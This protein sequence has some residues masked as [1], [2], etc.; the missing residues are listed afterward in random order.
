M[1]HQLDRIRDLDSETSR[2]QRLQFAQL[3]DEEYLADLWQR[4]DGDLA[5]LTTK[6]V[7]QAAEADN[8]VAR[9]IMAHA[10]EALGWAIAQA[11]T[12]L[13]GTSRCSTHQTGVAT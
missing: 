13:A 4:C 12:L 8:R 2:R 11:I 7:T 10:I 6:E 5:A 3:E 1:L 9:E